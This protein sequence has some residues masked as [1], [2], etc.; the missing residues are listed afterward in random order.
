M[1]Y[2]NVKVNYVNYD[3]V[4]FYLLSSNQTN[5]DGNNL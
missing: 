5:D 3:I 4:S 2:V 1:N